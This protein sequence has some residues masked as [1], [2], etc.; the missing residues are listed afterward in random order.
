[1]ELLAADHAI[2]DTSK[3]SNIKGAI[4]DFYILFTDLVCLGTKYP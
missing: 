2:G 1:M 4:F 3:I